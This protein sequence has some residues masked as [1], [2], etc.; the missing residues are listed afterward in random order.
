MK[1]KPKGTD[2]SFHGVFRELLKAFVVQKCSLGYNYHTSAAVLARFD[3]MTCKMGI[4]EAHLNRAVVD[5]WA[6]RR[7]NESERTQCH[8][9]NDLKQF[10]VYLV[11][12]GHNAYVPRVTRKKGNNWTFT[13][14]IFTFDELKRI[15]A[16]VDSIPDG[17][18]KPSPSHRNLIY[19]ALFRVLYGCG[20]RIQETLDLRLMDTDLNGGILT[21]H[22]GK[23]GK[24]RILPISGDVH[25]ALS[26]LVS[27]IHLF[28]SPET[29]LF[30]KIDGTPYTANTIYKFFRQ[31][32][33]KSGISH[34]GKMYGPRLHDFRHTFAVH[35]LRQL[36]LTGM[37]VYCALPILSTYLG[38]KSIGATERYVRLTTD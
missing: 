23:G 30:M 38:H 9:I 35:S 15:F 5:R 26:R 27:H 12:N 22:N 17:S 21:I 11:N 24:E 7:P 28:S 32:L 25:N 31:V 4:T 2:V 1:I 19:P 37:D 3:L 29:H 18:S 16:L 34:R 10:A 13:P 33:W 8:R 20:T 36:V 6:E 14:H